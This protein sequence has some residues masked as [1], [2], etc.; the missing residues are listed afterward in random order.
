MKP[1]GFILFDIGSLI[2]QLCLLENNSDE[3]EERLTHRGTPADAL[4]VKKSSTSIKRKPYK[5]A[6]KKK[7]L[8][9]KSK[10]IR[11]KNL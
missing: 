9:Y 6:L 2:A 4:N 8:I 7:N 11:K 5:N 10:N 1:S 3:G